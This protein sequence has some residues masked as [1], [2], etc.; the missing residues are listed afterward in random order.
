M[1]SRRNG[2][3]EPRWDRR[4][5]SLTVGRLFDIRVRIHYLFPVFML[6]LVYL[7]YPNVWFGLAAGAIMFAIVFAHE[8]GHCFG[9]RTV[10]GT[11]NDILLW[12]LG[13]LA[14][15]TPPHRPIETLLTAAAGPA[16]NLGILVLLAPVCAILGIFELSLFNPFNFLNVYDGPAEYVYVAFKLN[17]WCLLFNLLFAFYPF[18]GGLIV[19]ALLWNRLGYYQATLL[20][21]NIGVAA[22]AALAVLG[23]Y[24]AGA[25][26]HGYLLLSAIGLFGV[27]KSLEL[28]RQIELLGQLPENEFG[29]DFSRGFSSLEGSG[30]AGKPFTLLG[31]TKDRLLEWW[32]RRRERRQA[33]LD[34][35]L[36]RILDKIHAYGLESLS[37]EEKRLLQQASKRRRTRQ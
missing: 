4:T 28:R 20:A 10:G 8:L 5:W 27:L 11:A 23:V 3:P 17:Y 9:C 37:R 24:L 31:P 15:V 36:D 2:R 32:S 7:A 19:H 14:S 34:A 30:V 6:F 26:S 35:E 21:T 16:V 29:Y 1:A 18:D 22:G 25:W 13:G 12:P 33:H